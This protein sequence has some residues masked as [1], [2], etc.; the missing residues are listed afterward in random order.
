MFLAVLWRADEHLDQVV[1]QAVK[2]LAL[3]GPLE[4]RI[5]EIAWVQLEVVNVDRRIGEARANDHFD[6]FTFDAGI[7]LDQRM[8]VKQKLVLHTRQAIGS[9]A[10]IVDQDFLSLLMVTF[11]L[12]SWNDRGPGVSRPAR[13]KPLWNVVQPTRQGGRGESDGRP[14]P[15]CAGQFLQCKE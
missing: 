5:V 13:A 10:G 6:G 12:P 11:V 15:G 3:K 1:M 4:L 9:H 8:F 7:E 2:K 14:R